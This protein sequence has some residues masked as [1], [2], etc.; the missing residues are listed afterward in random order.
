M[1]N[2]VPKLRFP[3]FSGEWKEKRLKNGYELIS[4]QHLNPNEYSIV[5]N[6]KPYFT[7]PS[8]FT[9]S[10]ENIT[11]W[12]LI[13]GKKAKKG[14]IL[15]TVKG[16]GV[17]TLTILKLS[18]VVMGRQLMAITS[19]DSSTLFLSQYLKTKKE[20]F[21]SLARGNMIPGLSRN[22]ILDLKCCS[23]LLSEQEKIANFLSSVDIKI[24]KLE[25][26]K[27]LLEKYKKGM[28]QKL[29]SQKLR[30]KDDNRNDYPTW[31]EKRLG[32]VIRYFNGAAFPEKYQGSQDKK[33]PF[34][35]V[36]DMNLLLNRK[37]MHVSNN[38]ISE[39]EKVILNAKIAL[40]ETVIFPKVGAALL[41]NKRRILKKNSIFDNNIMGIIGTA[42]L[43]NSYLYYFMLT[44]D[45]G[46]YVQ[47]GALPSISKKIIDNLEISL[48]SLSE[49]EKIANFL[50]SIDRK[51]ELIERELEKNK[52]FKKGLLQ[53]MFV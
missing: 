24:E 48:P 15:F 20:Y 22:D 7:G 36:S 11:K 34:Y 47:V 28:M 52:E 37:E 10:I 50:S 21:E 8:D 44:I 31:E 42:K 53:Q 6:N 5:K 4:G 23:P 45:F 9:D 49:Q 27:E 18:E 39:E 30:F 32:E 38:S 35:K 46:L 13:E 43:N 29:F 41:T 14:D 26:K 16:S 40:P 1:K 51:I 19:K 12:S 25:K 17:G 33:Y 2:K 3:E